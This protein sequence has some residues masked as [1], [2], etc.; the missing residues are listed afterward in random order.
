[1]IWHYV[2]MRMAR[3]RKKKSD[4]ADAIFASLGLILVAVVLYPK[5]LYYVAIAA[6]ATVVLVVAALLIRHHNRSALAS[7]NTTTIVSNV[8]VARTTEQGADLYPLW[9]AITGTGKPTVSPERWSIELLDAL[10]WKRFEMVCAKYFEM[11]GFKSRTNLSGADGGVDIHLF[12]D[13]SDRPD[14][15]VQCK[16]WTR[17]VRINMVRELLG[18][19]S[20]GGWTKGIFITT[21]DYTREARDFAEGNGISLIDGEGLLA[22]IGALAPEQQAELLILAT[23]GDY[24]TPTCPSCGIKMMIRTNKNDESQFWGCLNYPRCRVTFHHPSVV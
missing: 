22:R 8:Q 5:V 12:A 2:E 19:M 20:A 11:Q 15:V 4:A 3:R 23:D 16:A 9:N 1:M 17:K 7:R 13:G 24:L 10:E 18:V 21:G 14:S 6:I